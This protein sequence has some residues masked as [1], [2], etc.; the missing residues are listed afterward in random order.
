M[1]RP[2]LTSSTSCT[3]VVDTNVFV[4]AAFN[5]GSHSAWIIEAVRNGRLRLVWNE[6]TRRETRKILRQIPPVSWEAFAELFREE[7][8]HRGAV[9]EAWF[10]QVRDA[11]DRKF[12]ALA[13]A[14]QA[15]LITQD[16]DL[17]SQRA[18]VGIRILTPTEF[19]EG[20]RERGHLEQPEERA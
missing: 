4:A 18:G 3:V 8:R 9:N 16:D 10:E 20:V 12:A 14:A 1:E 2:G 6:A 11:D 7:N 15:T 19:V 5:R 13:Y 17:L